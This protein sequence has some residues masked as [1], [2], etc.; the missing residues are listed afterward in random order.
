[1]YS[2][3]ESKTKRQMKKNKIYQIC[4]KKVNLL[5]KTHWSGFPEPGGPPGSNKQS[6]SISS[7]PE[8]EVQLSQD[9]AVLLP[10]FTVSIINCNH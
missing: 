6:A 7:G 8:H 2:Q 10:Q 5:F 4:L 9:S 3:L 1:M